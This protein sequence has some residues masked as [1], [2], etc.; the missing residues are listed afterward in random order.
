MNREQYILSKS[1]VSKLLLRLFSRTQ[2]LIIFDIGGCE[3]EDSIRYSR[4]FPNSQIFVFEPLPSNQKLILENLKKYHSK[5]ITLVPEALSD[6]RGVEEF[7]VSSGSPEGKKND[8]SWD[9]GNKSS[10]LLP[11]D[12]HI[13]IHP[14]VKFEKTISVPTNT[15]NYFLFNKS[16]LEIDFIHMDV[17][18]VELK[19]L[20]GAESHL[21][22]IKAIWL[23]V[24]NI[25]LYKNQ[26]RRIEVENFMKSNGFCLLK[27][28]ITGDSGDQMYINRKYFKLKSLLQDLKKFFQLI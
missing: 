16:I 24:S 22:N 9:Y 18:G 4:T 19:V 8:V 13:E 15:L 25:T 7:Y 23:E 26:P 12:K 5:N 1:P 14:W 28:A 2:K 21:Q 10:S 27:N 17:Q 6:S 11:P 3:G 20:A